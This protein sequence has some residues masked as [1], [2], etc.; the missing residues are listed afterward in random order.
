[1]TIG[2]DIVVSKYLGQTLITLIG[3]HDTVGVIATLDF[4][5]LY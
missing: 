5:T 4:R 1:V 2:V 3:L